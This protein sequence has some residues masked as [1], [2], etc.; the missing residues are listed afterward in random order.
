MSTRTGAELRAPRG[1]AAESPPQPWFLSRNSSAPQQGNSRLAGVSVATRA[2]ARGHTHAS[3][4]SGEQHHEAQTAQRA[5][6]RPVPSRYRPRDHV[7]PGPVPVRF[8]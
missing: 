4:G 6:H 1:R 2:A 3:K 7:V 8:Q 5:S